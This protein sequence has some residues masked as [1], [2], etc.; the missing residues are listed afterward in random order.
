MKGE[1]MQPPDPSDLEQAIDEWRIGDKHDAE[2]A[3][4]TLKRLRDAATARIEAYERLTR[5]SRRSDADDEAN[6]AGPL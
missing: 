4:G 2:K 6:P 1:P 3:L 5:D